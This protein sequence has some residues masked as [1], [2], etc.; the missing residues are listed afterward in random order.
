MK[1]GNEKFDL[2]FLCHEKDV[3]ALRRNLDYARK[4]VGGYRKIFVLSKENFFKEDKDLIFI[5]EKIFPFNKEEIAKY[6]PEGRAGWYFQQ[7]LKLYFIEAMGKK[8][9]DNV[10]I[11]DADC[12]FIRKTS[13]FRGK[14]PLYNFEI[15]YHDPYYKILEKVF[16]FGKQD[17]NLSG[18]VHHLMY[19]RKY[20]SEILNFVRKR[21]GNELWKEIMD[22]ANKNTI[23]GFSEQD[24][25]FNYILKFHKD[26][27]KIRRIKFIDFPYN[28]R[29]W[30]WLFKHLGYSYIASHDYLQKKRFSATRS[31]LIEFLKV[32]GIKVL[33]KRILIKLRILRVK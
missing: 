20:M 3:D 24:L 16:G 22:K 31:L 8:C 14:K 12:A 26:K 25:Y 29:F 2:L 15:G 33:I 27:I 28:S 9:L 17:S 21:S 5:D 30:V 11:I 23:S 1:D 18:T 19:Q 10:L 32:L 4:N 6:A 7:F 13:F